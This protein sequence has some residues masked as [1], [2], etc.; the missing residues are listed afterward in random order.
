MMKLLS[1]LE[2]VDSAT[3][4]ARKDEGNTSAGIAHGTG[5]HE[6]PNETI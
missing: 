5:P 1:Q 2:Q 3:P 4:F 6:A